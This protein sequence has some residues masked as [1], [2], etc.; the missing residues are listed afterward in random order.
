MKWLETVAWVVNYFSTLLNVRGGESIRKQ[1]VL[2]ISML[3]IV[4]AVFSIAVTADELQNQ[5]K[6]QDSNSLISPQVNVVS[7]SISNSTNSTPKNETSNQTANC[8]IVPSTIGQSSNQTFNCTNITW[9]SQSPNQTLNR[10]AIRGILEQFLAPVLN[11]TGNITQTNTTGEPLNKL[12]T[13]VST[14]IDKIKQLFSVIQSSGLNMT[15]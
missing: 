14:L 13:D 9:T 10:T 5:S 3:F 11:D 8:T 4:F 2:T 15:D 6:S 12:L 1:L 7:N